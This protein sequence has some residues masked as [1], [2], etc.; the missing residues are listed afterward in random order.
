MGNIAILVHNGV[1]KFNGRTV[2]A[3]CARN[4]LY[5]C[6]FIGAVIIELYRAL[7]NFHLIVTLAIGA[8]LMGSALGNIPLD[9][10]GAI[11]IKFAAL[12]KCAWAVRAVI[13]GARPHQHAAGDGFAFAH[14]IAIRIGLRHIVANDYGNVLG[15]GIAIGIG[16]SDGN[17]VGYVILSGLAMLVCGTLE[18]E[19]VGQLA[20]G[21]IIGEIV[22]H[23]LIGANLDTLH[24]AAILPDN[25]VA[26]DD[27]GQAIGSIDQHAAMHHHA[28]IGQIALKDLQNIAAN[29]GSGVAAHGRHRPGWIEGQVNCAIRQIH[30]IVRSKGNGIVAGHIGTPALVIGVAANGIWPFIPLKTTTHAPVKAIQMLNAAGEI[31]IVIFMET[32]TGGR[33]GAGAG[34]GGWRDILRVHGLEKVR[35]RDL[36]AINIE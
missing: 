3:L 32:A 28:A 35:S 36:C 34:A 6:K 16:D 22:E 10:D 9:R 17:G 30:W 4:I 20:C 5:C 21:G 18:N 27:A 7:G 2:A 1:T 25:P 11:G 26:N 33:R 29:A 14:L 13:V 24:G 19:I 12:I 8:G 31:H 15:V 23:A